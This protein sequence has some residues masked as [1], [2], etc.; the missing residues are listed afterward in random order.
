[1]GFRYPIDK[2]KNKIDAIEC[3]NSRNV[4][5]SNK[6][7]FNAA[8][9]LNIAKTAGSDAH[10]KFGIG[11]A[12]TIFDGDLRNAIKKNKTKV[13]GSA[14]YGPFGGFLSFLRNRIY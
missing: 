12:Y 5:W 3:F 7:A 1:L 14:L 2:L 8:E 9:R 13:E 4:L 6:L 10:F 11:R